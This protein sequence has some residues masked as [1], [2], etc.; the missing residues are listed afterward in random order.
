MP[1]SP[2]LSG[3]ADVDDFLAGHVGGDDA[4]LTAALAR[5][6]AAGLPSI[7]VSALQGKFLHLLARLIGA[8]RILE[9]GTLG[10][11]SGIWL[12]RALAEGG[13]LDTIEIDPAH[14]AV[15]AANFAAAGVADRVTLHRGAGLEVLKDL[16]GPYDM[17]FID[18]DKQNNADYFDFAVRL[19][20]PG[21]LIIVDNVVRNGEILAPADEKARGTVAL[22]GAIRNDARVEMTALQ[23]AG[24]KGWDGILLARV[25]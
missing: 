22:F 19:S 15:A 5:A 3:F 14:S 7:A 9:I 10:G 25:K 13:R 11:Y 17:A 23:L 12:A 6:G 4:V 21:G 8:R 18:A 1:P 20:R 2:T 16:S 24:A